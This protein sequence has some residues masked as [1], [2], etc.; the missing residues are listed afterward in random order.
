MAMRGVTIQLLTLIVVSRGVVMAY[1]GQL[2]PSFGSQGVVSYPPGYASSLVIQPDGKLVAAGSGPTGGIAV[3]YASNGALDESFGSGGTA[4]TDPLEYPTALLLQPDG[5]VV[6]A[7]GSDTRTEFE[8]MRLD[9]A[10]AVDGAFGSA[11]VVRTPIGSGNAAVYAIALQ[12]DGKIVAAGS[13][14]SATGAFLGVARYETDGTL[15]GSFGEGGIVLTGV[16]GTGYYAPA[17]VA[18][19]PDG[20]IVV[21]STTADPVVYYRALIVRYDTTGVLD[22]TFG[23]DGSSVLPGP[24]ATYAVGVV[25]Q[26]DGKIV[27]AAD[28]IH[29]AV[30]FLLARW[31]PDGSPDATFGTGGTALGPL[32]RSG[33]FASALVQEADGNLIVAGTLYRHPITPTS[34]RVALTRYLP[35]GGLDASFGVDGNIVTSVAAEPHAAAAGDQHVVIAGFGVPAGTA[36]FTLA[37]YFTTGPPAQRCDLSPDPTVECDDGNPCTYDTCDV[38]TPICRHD[39]VSGS[40][41]ETGNE[42]T[43][44]V[45]DPEGTCVES[46][47]GPIP[48]TDDGDP[49][50]KDT[51][52][53]NYSS[54]PVTV[55][56]THEPDFDLACN[57]PLAPRDPRLSMFDV[58]GRTRAR[59]FRFRWSHGTATKSDFG[60]PIS[61]TSYRFCAWTFTP[62]DPPQGH[63]VLGV[64]IEAGSDCS[65]SGCWTER[66]H[67]WKFH[68]RTGTPDGATRLLLSEGRLPGNARID[69]KGVGPALAL[70]ALPLDPVSPQVFVQLDSSDGQCWGADLSEIVSNTSRHYYARS[71]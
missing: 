65:E 45:C 30:N 63:T 36:S 53:P 51:C 18:I 2:D 67:G 12:P 26:P 47:L 17:A 15:D 33:P 7:G 14:T 49:C 9:G 24:E 60:E 10:G 27:A 62:T 48:C 28:T 25:L 3:R 8:L 54:S 35:D 55:Q 5:K 66:E 59:L 57:G 41:C 46:V 61:G 13:V 19:Q 43:I 56:C 34:Q 6:I 40:P 70:P 38:V 69:L 58:P 32:G 37:R 21:A 22:S 23:T 1:P 71:Q 39:P 68:S 16:G 44:G 50:S 52:Q 11:G 4:T 64:R 29:G 31:N 20:R 42:C